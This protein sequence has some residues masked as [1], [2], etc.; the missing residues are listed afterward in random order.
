MSQFDFVLQQVV[1]LAPYPPESRDFMRE[2]LFANPARADEEIICLMQESGQPLLMS[3]ISP[4]PARRW[5][6]TFPGESWHDSCAIAFS[7]S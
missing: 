5:V 4:E 7:R 1:A 2:P 3:A 6:P